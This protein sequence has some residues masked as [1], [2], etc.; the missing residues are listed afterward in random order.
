MSKDTKELEKGFYWVR[1]YGNWQVSSWDN[2]WSHF[3]YY[4]TV[5]VQEVGERVTQLPKE[6]G[7]SKTQLRDAMLFASS[8]LSSVSGIDKYIDKL[9]APTQD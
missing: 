8:H 5:T 1:I 3:D 2:G 7:Y 6:A 4:D 9:E